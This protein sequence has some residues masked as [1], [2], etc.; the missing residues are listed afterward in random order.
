MVLSNL[1][2]NVFVAVRSLVVLVSGIGPEGPGLI[3]D[4]AKDPTRRVV[5]VLV[6]SVIN[7]TRCVRARKVRDS[8]SIVV[9]HYGCCLWR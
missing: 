9:S 5:Y 8:E 3:L 1:Q 7:E 4:T 6:K 2:K